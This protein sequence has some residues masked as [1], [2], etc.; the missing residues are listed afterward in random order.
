MSEN[1]NNNKQTQKNKIESFL[2]AYLFV[3]FGK[4]TKVLI[5]DVSNVS[6]SLY[7]LLNVTKRL[8]LKYRPFLL[9]QRHRSVLF[10]SKANNYI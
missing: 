8:Y 6:L 7:F 2:F 3:R 5:V 1:N 4:S 9:T 10:F